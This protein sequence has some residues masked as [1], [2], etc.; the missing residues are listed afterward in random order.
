[1]DLV[2]VGLFSAGL[3]ACLAGGLS[4]L[5]ALLFGLALFLAYGRRTGL[6]WHELAVTALEGVK[7]VKN[8]LFTFIL[9]GVL[10]A[11]WR[12]AGTIA[13]IVCQ[14]SDLIRPSLFLL[15]AFLLNCCVSLLTGTSFG[16]A[17]TMGV[18]CAA[19]GT[20][21]GVP[22]WLTGGAVLSGAYFGDRCS[23]VSTSALL[24]A[25]VTGTEIYDNIRQMMRTTLV[26]FVLTCA[27]Y[28]ALGAFSGA[29]GAAPD[30]RALFSR[31]FSLSWTSLLPAAAVLAAALL[32]VNVKWAMACGIAVSLPVGRWGQ[33][34]SA[35]SLA[36]MAVLGFRAADA[37]VDALMGGG[38]LV[39]MLRVGGIVCLSSSYSGLFAKTGLLNGVKGALE[40]LARRTSP[41]FA[42]AA[43][44]VA[45]GMIAC[46]QALTI[47]M[48]AQ[49]CGGLD[50][51][52]EQ[53]AHD[54][55]DTAVVIAPLVPWSIA[56]AAPLAAV[57]A[58]SEA[59]TVAF[60][61]YLLPL[62]RL[63]RRPTV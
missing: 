10:T 60:F 44:S 23:L 34:V 40:R 61:L 39:S 38:G 9:I 49:L 46:N 53:L 27:A 36:R 13:V 57:G 48:V 35:A 59:L 18:I 51:R 7:A 14:A 54:I 56:G 55:E 33:G 32:K 4:I 3:L 19:I 21:L 25:A 2:T 42:T 24:V 11:F 62:Y 47:L 15:M 31:E 50:E 17:A 1:M 8:I 22:L 12:A 52:P 58:G 37:E 28:A 26:P 45:A 41:L 30:L 20:A 63:V 16:T 5:W 29:S 43:A 6:S